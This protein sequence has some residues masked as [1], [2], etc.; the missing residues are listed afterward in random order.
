MW[1]EKNCYV[2]LWIE[3]LHA[4]RLDARAV[5]PVV[6]AA[7]FED[8]QW[9]FFKPS[10]E[11]LFDLYGVEVQEL[12]VWKPLLTHAVDQLA[13]GKL[14]SAEADAFWLPDAVG[15]DYRRNHTKTTIVLNALDTSGQTLDYFHNSAY[16]RLSG[17]DFRELFRVD[18][19]ADPA[20]LP[21]FAEFIRI[22]R[23]HRDEPAALARKSLQL[24]RR[25]L[26]RRPLH[27]PVARLGRHFA[28]HLPV[29]QA[30]GIDYYHKWAFGTVRQ[31]GAS[32]EL[33]AG[34]LQWLQDTGVLP[35]TPAT[36]SFQFI[37][38]NCK[39][40]ILKGARAVMTRRPSDFTNLFDSMAEAWATAFSSLEQR[41]A[42]PS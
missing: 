25:Y 7:D 1:P 35:E 14:I 18:A 9:T 38:S 42:D 13:A 30:E 11:D 16:Y 5:M 2:D 39:A 3:V 36:E 17:E 31:L 4:L 23:I 12:N 41:L 21:L 37:S 29:M 24:V 8:D 26:G 27:N 33:A 32:A 6:L 20:F 10:H 22:D 28:E 34:N 19:A 40:L 15:T